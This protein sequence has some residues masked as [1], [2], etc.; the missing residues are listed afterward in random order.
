MK[1]PDKSLVAPC[2]MICWSCL[3]YLRNKNRCQ[4]CGS[5]DMDKWK[6]CSRC[7]IRK[8]SLL[9]GTASKFCYDCEKFPCRRLR[10]LDKRYRTKYSTSFL[11]NL[12][13]IKNNGLELFIKNE[14]VKRRCPVCG[15]TICIHRGYCLNC[16]PGG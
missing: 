16:N 7:S 9:A 11:D 12:A 8:C 2:G 13:S 10:D 5:E 1:Y 3:A 4:G 6:S 14:Y 15:G